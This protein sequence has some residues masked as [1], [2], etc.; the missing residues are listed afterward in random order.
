MP[1]PIRTNLRRIRQ[2]QGLS[3]TELGA[4]AGIGA[5]YVA[6]IESGQKCP[7]MKVAIKL[8]K[9]LHTKVDDIFFT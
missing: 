6:F 7:S 1:L 2:A 4:K 8:A 9:V 3:Q 5:R